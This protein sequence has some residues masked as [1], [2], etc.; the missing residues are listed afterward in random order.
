MN[1]RNRS[2][3]SS[4][5]RS[6]KGLAIAIVALGVVGFSAWKYLGSGDDE[7]DYIFGKVEMGDIQDLVTATGILEPRDYVD[8]GAQVSGQIE[9]LYVEVG[10]VVKAGDVLAKIDAEQASARVEANRANLASALITLETR[11][12]DLRKNTRDYERQQALMA[13][14][15]TTEEALLNAKTAYDNSVRSVAAQEQSIKQQQ[16]N[17]RIEERNLQYTEIK[18]PID[19][20]VMS[21]AVREGQTVNASQ[22]VPNVMQI[23]NLKTM[24]VR[25]DVSEADVA[26]VVPGMQVYFTTLGAGQERRYYSQVKRIEPKPKVQQGVV[27]YPALFDVDNEDEVLKPQATTQVF[28]VAAE[29]RDVKI[30]PMAALQ[31][32]Q[33]IAR[34]MAQKQ[35]DAGEGERRAGPEGGGAALAAR[36][37]EA[38]NAAAA[39]GGSAPATGAAGEGAAAPVAGG[40]EA[41][42]GAGGERQR[43]QGGFGGQRGGFGNFDPSRMTPE[44]LEEMR[45][46][47]SRGGGPG[48]PGGFGGGGGFRGMGMPGGGGA[49]APR[50]RR[51]VVM[52][53]KAD[54][55]LEQR[56]V[57]VG[58]ND[59][60]L[61]EVIEGL[62]VGEEVVIGKREAE[63]QTG[64][65]ATNQ[66]NNNNFRGNQG[67]FPGGGGGF[68]PF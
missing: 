5:L 61:G 52:V 20:T 62:E 24:T 7:G 60:V 36:G 25:A 40:G 26:K 46:R 8:V 45:A 11:R 53:K 38:P 67:G 1:D 63:P 51:G 39:A 35:R 47:F 18:A 15:A 55:T 6:R 4:R 65:T 56:Q 41:P 57:V 12:E 44:Q 19:G 13:E 28:F 9:E 23:A 31:Q 43:G 49:G 22:N 29:A 68:R 58:V 37:G 33:Q 2:S 30:V 3:F 48:G 14:K 66:Q 50:Q 10:D 32:G 34:E 54:G 59:R 64:P 17:M 16:A 21:I 42:R 27:L